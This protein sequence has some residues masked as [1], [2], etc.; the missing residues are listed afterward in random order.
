[1]TVASVP[2]PTAPSSP[3]A[4]A[5]GASGAA[6][7]GSDPA[8]S[9][10]A[11]MLAGL[12]GNAA[13]PVPGRGAHGGSAAGGA[14]KAP[15]DASAP[16]DPVMLAMLAALAAALPHADTAGAT[17]PADGSQTAADPGTTAPA[18]VPTAAEL[19]ALDGSAAPAP[20]PPRAHRRA[21]GGRALGA[22]AVVPPTGP[23]TKPGTDR[24]NATD[25]AP[26]DR[27]ARDRRVHKARDR[28]RAPRK[29]G[30]RT[31]DRGDDDGHRDARRCRRARER[32]REPRRTPTPRRSRST[33]GDNAMITAANAAVD[34]APAGD[35]TATA[36]PAPAT[37][38]APPP[39][40][41]QLAAFIRPLHR[42]PDGSYQIRIEMRPPELGRVDMRVEMRDGVLH[43]SIHAEHAQTGDLMR[44]A[45]DDLRARLEA[46]GVNTGQLTVDAQGAGTSGRE[47]Q[48]ATPQRLDDPAATPETPVVV[49]APA[50][51]DSDQLLDVRI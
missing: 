42:A 5:S 24:T 2:A 33:A 11:A 31:R 37:A 50:T 35:V 36:A 48:A 34:R 41:D 22:A 51:T 21:S 3:S 23:A 29:P 46:D 45:L 18:A 28:T 20:A 6:N 16:A 15:G 47:N 39:P 1:M 32:H 44:A 8:D 40:A 12:N 27:P 14:G 38:P 10:F 49:T 7:A 17:T 19:A 4:G 9:G 25:D 13:D 30:G 43:A 26:D